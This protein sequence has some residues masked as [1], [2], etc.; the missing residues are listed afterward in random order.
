MSRVSSARPS[1]G[2]TALRLR[3][4]ASRF[5][6]ETRFEMKRTDGSSSDRWI[7]GSKKVRKSIDTTKGLGK[8]CAAEQG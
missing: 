2:Q 5:A 6:R 3:R 7:T 4:E 8:T 1:A